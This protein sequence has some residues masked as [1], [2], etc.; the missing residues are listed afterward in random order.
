MAGRLTNMTEAWS[1]ALSSGSFRNQ[2][3]LTLLVFAGICMHNFHYLRVWQ[4]RPGTQINDIILNQLPPRD[5]SL[6]IFLLEYCTMLLVTIIT[7]QHPDRLVK[8]LQMFGLI[9]L[10][11]TMCIY[12]FPLEPP[13]DM[14]FLSD[15]FAAFFL[16]SKDTLVT[17]DLFFSGHISALALLV[18][19][20]P[21]RYVKAWALMATVLVGGLILWQHVHYSLDV[22]FAPLASFLSY[23]VILFIHRES[24][25]GLELQGQESF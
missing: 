10:T 24:R 5:F 1:K 9:I 11:R 18:L 17:K 3:F 21:N 12:F 2:F 8:G 16:H 4:D 7:I 22:V 6:E 23:K 20:S 13:R 19:I 15:P 25:Y 14:I